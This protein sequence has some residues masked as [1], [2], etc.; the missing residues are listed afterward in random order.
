MLATFKKA[1]EGGGPLR[2]WH[3]G[4]IYKAGPFSSEVERLAVNQFVAGSN[5]AGASRGMHPL[6]PLDY[7]TSRHLLIQ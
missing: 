3:G 1:I 7:H 4:V 6:F 5:P 2:R